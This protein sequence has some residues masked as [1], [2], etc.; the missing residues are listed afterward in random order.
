[1]IWTSG[2]IRGL[3][4]IH[5][6]VTASLVIALVVCPGRLFKA[7][8]LTIIAVVAYIVVAPFAIRAAYQRGRWRFIRQLWAADYEVCPHCGYGLHGLPETHN[9]PECGAGYTKE[10]LLAEWHRW[11]F[12][13]N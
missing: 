2:I 7:S 5:L 11:E 9:C 13:H 1:M 10:S 6:A 8:L 3:N 12:E 4:A